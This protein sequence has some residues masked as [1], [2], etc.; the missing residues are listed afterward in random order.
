VAEVLRRSLRPQDLAG[1][2][3]G[4]EFIVA[5]PLADET[6]AIQASER[7]REA[8]ASHPF[9]HRETQPDGVLSIS[10]GVAV[11]PVDGQNSTELIGQADQ[12][13]YRAKGA[14]RNRVCRQKKFEIGDPDADVLQAPAEPAAL[15]NPSRPPAR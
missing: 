10:G 14:G 9:A 11:F 2:Y 6:Q 15:R 7:I 3:G 8:I 4:E 13:L 12:G 5:M 1:R